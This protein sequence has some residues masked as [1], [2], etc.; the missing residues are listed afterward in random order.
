MSAFGG[1]SPMP[2]RLGGSPT[3]GWNAAQHARVAADLLACTYTLPFACVSF[4]LSGDGST[5][6][7]DSYNSMPGCGLA[8][9][10]TITR[11][12]GGYYLIQWAPLWNDAYQRPEP[13]A[14]RHVFATLRVASA[15]KVSAQ[16]LGDL[17][18]VEV[19]TFDNTGSLADAAVTVEVL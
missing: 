7:I 6:V 3:D 18:T 1:F 2:L 16:V 19:R 5:V 10:P 11:F 13:I 12:T 17:A 15:F 8:F 4:H 9:A 14:L